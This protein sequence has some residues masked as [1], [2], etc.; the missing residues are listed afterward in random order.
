MFGF[1]KKKQPSSTD[2]GAPEPAQLKAEAEAFFAKRAFFAVAQERID[3]VLAQVLPQNAQL[4]QVHRDDPQALG[5]YALIVVLAEDIK[6]Y[7]MVQPGA[8]VHPFAPFALAPR[9]VGIVL[10][11]SEDPLGMRSD[12]Q[13]APA[14]AASFFAAASQTTGAL[15]THLCTQI[16]VASMQLHA[17]AMLLQKQ[18]YE[19]ADVGVSLAHP[20]IAPLGDARCPP[21]LA[22][23]IELANGYLH[24]LLRPAAT[25]LRIMGTL[26]A[27]VAV[28]LDLDMAVL[29]A[30]KNSAPC[31]HYKTANAQAIER[32]DGSTPM[33]VAL[34]EALAHAYRYL[35]VDETVVLSPGVHALLREGGTW[36]AFEKE[37]HSCASKGFVVVNTD[38][39]DPLSDEQESVQEAP[40]APP[41]PLKHE[42]AQSAASTYLFSMFD[43][44]DGKC[45]SAVLED[46]VAQKLGEALGPQALAAPIFLLEWLHQ[47]KDTDQL[48]G[49]KPLG[50]FLSAR[51]L[52][53]MLVRCPDDPLLEGSGV[54]GTPA[55]L[56]ALAK[57]GA[58]QLQL[59]QDQIQD[60]MGAYDLVRQGALNLSELHFKGH[61]PILSPAFIEYLSE[62]MERSKTPWRYSLCEA[63]VL[64]LC[65]VLA[66]VEHS[67][68]ALPDGIGWNDLQAREQGRAL[69]NLLL[70]GSQRSRARWLY[71]K[72]EKTVSAFDGTIPWDAEQ[73]TKSLS[74]WVFFVVDGAVRLSPS[75]WSALKSRGGVFKQWNAW[76]F[77]S[78]D[79]P[80]MLTVYEDRQPVDDSDEEQAARHGAPPSVTEPVPP[81][82]DTGSAQT[83]SSPMDA[84]QDD[85]SDP[86]A[87]FAA[88]M[89]R[90]HAL[91]AM[92][93][94]PVRAMVQLLVQSAP[95]VAAMA[96][97]MGEVRLYL[98]AMV[99]QLAHLVRQ[100]DWYGPDYPDEAL[101]PHAPLAVAAHLLRVLF[102]SHEDPLFESAPDGQG[103][104]L[105]QLLLQMFQKQVDVPLWEVQQALNTVVAL[106]Q[107]SQGLLRQVVDGDFQGLF[108][109]TFS[110]LQEQWEPHEH[111]VQGQMLWHGFVAA[112]TY[113]AVLMQAGKEGYRQQGQL[114]VKL[115]E[116]LDYEALDPIQRG[117]LLRQCL[118]LGVNALD[119]QWL[120]G[121][122]D[123]FEHHSSL[124]DIGAQMVFLLAK[125]RLQVPLAA[126]SAYLTMRHLAPPEQACS[127]VTMVGSRYV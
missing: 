29:M 6:R 12:P 116:G 64:T 41:A 7:G 46:E 56:S 75:V 82:T 77:E 2:N 49:D 4:A 127:G 32:Y 31:W 124:T 97:D 34:H 47:L 86:Q 23:G 119:A 14:R 98:P 114:D 36:G 3:K 28:R 38:P 9:L 5:A 62:T 91:F 83:A 20:H 44:Y 74:C 93:M 110:Q 96:Q 84:Q 79:K 89:A 58:A 125:D 117:K 1:G 95:P 113:V 60:L 59:P 45:T 11:N 72:D 40:S 42:E 78:T 33:S 51:H 71:L 16:L 35:V 115:P 26:D 37:F 81:A 122:D 120:V 19:G 88:V 30:L 68:E 109:D 105:F 106:H 100:P 27:D 108:E 15:D 118:I 99:V 53:T 17:C 69:R 57:K 80:V 48:R 102:H 85:A 50:T 65:Y 123:A 87:H 126:L 22:L 18:I 8:P 63:V 66:L 67:Q 103:T 13:G 92:P 70:D 25:V 112:C 76:F 52:L 121:S 94:E 10:H 21:A 24:A 90:G 55:V 54:S 104:E 73:Y 111:G 101:Q 61:R 39:T 107:V 43:R